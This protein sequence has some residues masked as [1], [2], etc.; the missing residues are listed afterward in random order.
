MRQ[1]QSKAVRPAPP[2][3]PPEQSE[4]PRSP[5]LAREWAIHE[6]RSA[7]LK[8]LDAL[9]SGGAE[10][11]LQ[12]RRIVNGWGDYIRR[13]R[14]DAIGVF[15]PRFPEYSPGRLHKDFE[16][17]F[18]RRLAQHAGYRCQWMRV[19]ERS[20]GG[21]FHIHAFVAGTSALTIA[22]IR[23]HWIRNLG[24]RTLR[25][26]PGSGLLRSQDPPSVRR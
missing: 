20:K 3:S 24:R 18:I 1:D 13:Y 19:I 6:D 15:S 10:V 22:A 23:S 5:G 17:G 8:P 25:P 21:V 11:A 14:W 2:V 4:S 12:R 26:E 7:R 9:D 16:D